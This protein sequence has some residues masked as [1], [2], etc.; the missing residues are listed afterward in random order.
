M[1]LE[2]I[3][4]FI[5]LSSA[6]GSILA[7][8]ILFLKKILKK[9][10]NAHWSYYIWFIL[11]IRLIMPLAPESSISI[12]NLFDD[13]NASVKVLQEDIQKESSPN[14]YSSESSSNENNIAKE[15]YSSSEQTNELLPKTNTTDITPKEGNSLVT[16][17]IENN[18]SYMSILSVIWLV[19]IIILILYTIFA[20]M[21]LWFNLRKES[22]S[23]SEQMLSLWEECKKEMNIHR[24]IPLITSKNIHTPTLI[25]FIKIQLVFPEKMINK[26]SN[27]EI[28]YIFLHELSHVKRLDTVTNWIMVIIQSIH[29]FNPV[30]WFSFHKMRQDCE[31]SCDATVLSHLSKDEHKEYGMT[32]I[33]L[34]EMFSNKYYIPGTSS[35][36]RSKS[37]IKRRIKMITQFKKHPFIWSVIGIGLVVILAFIG[38]TNPIGSTKAD[39]HDELTDKANILEQHQA[40]LNSLKISYDEF[41]SS[42]QN[43]VSADYL[44]SY[45]DTLIFGANGKEYKVSDIKGLSE[46]ELSSLQDEL[47]RVRKELGTNNPEVIIGFSKSYD[48]GIYDW[49]YVYSKT[50][51]KDNNGKDTGMITTKRYT[52]EQQGEEWRIINVDSDIFPATIDDKEILGALLDESIPKLKYQTINNEN[53]EYIFKLGLSSFYEIR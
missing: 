53:F 19:G 46:K 11:L 49:K 16:K 17:S 30:V 5:L 52:F 33:S 47:V 29:W 34:L 10:L 1:S 23:N 32:I 44:A 2:Q 6:M 31:I 38:L 15:S 45:D 24:S 26:L 48:A 4:K 22:V 14:T 39:N 3:F 9:Q 41:E 35:I 8:L 18:I 7:V 42:V 50:I 12:F 43:I 36:L 25:S 13:T 20:N 37:G 51:F 27:E 21:K 28:R 40:Y